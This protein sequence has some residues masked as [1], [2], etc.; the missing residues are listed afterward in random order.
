MVMLDKN[1][2]P[3]VLQR[4][5][6]PPEQIFIKGADLDELLLRP[7]IAVVGS[8][9]IT[10]YGRG[11]TQMLVRELVKAG[12][13]IVSGL[14]LGADSVAHEACLE[15]GGQTIAVLPA[16]LDK[17]YPSNHGNLANQIIAQG[18]AIVTEYGDNTTPY[19][20]NFLARNRIIAAL[21]DGVLVPEAAARSGSLNTAAYALELNL[22]LM[23]VPGNITSLLSDGTNNL[24][25]AGAI[26]V[27]NVQD[28]FHALD[29]QPVEPVQRTISAGNPAERSILTL[30]QKGMSDGHDLLKASKLA[31]A[32]F[33]QH[34]TMLELTGRIRAIGANHWALA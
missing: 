33:N 26:P 24:I 7:R 9:K 13:V 17:I 25:K 4:L 12:I 3:Q 14:A 11:V 1:E 19:K 21:S 23:A 18:G 30:I 16:G 10:P 6:T 32:E 8:R 29:W 20:S 15:A 27:T 34:L 5:H 22:P 28:I 2:L 31:A